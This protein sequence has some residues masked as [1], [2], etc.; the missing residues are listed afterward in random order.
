MSIGITENTDA[1]DD[2][3]ALEPINA[4]LSAKSIASVSSVIQT[5]ALN[6]AARVSTRQPSHWA[7][8][9]GSA[10]LRRDRRTCRSGWPRAT[11]ARRPSRKA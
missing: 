11:S 5:A 9:A 10:V 8:R 2:T 4:T 3:D 6:P 1:A 7:M